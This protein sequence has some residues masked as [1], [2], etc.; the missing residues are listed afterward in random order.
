MVSHLS[1]K[2]LEDLK[3]EKKK[4]KWID[5]CY[6]SVKSKAIYSSIF[7]EMSGI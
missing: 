4:N 2:I 3:I 6:A 1:S 7:K 5:Y